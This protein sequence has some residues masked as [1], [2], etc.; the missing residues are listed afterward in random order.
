MIKI[1]FTADGIKQ[2]FTFPELVGNEVEFVVLP[3]QP[4]AAGDGD[5]GYKFMKTTG[6][7]KF[8][9]VP[10]AGQHGIIFY[11]IL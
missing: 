7:I 6:T 9:S 2:D 11:N 5:T 1:E 8:G 10:K 3:P 4:V